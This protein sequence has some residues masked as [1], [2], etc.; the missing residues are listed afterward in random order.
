MSVRLVSIPPDAEFLISYCARVSNP[1]NQLSTK[2]TNL[3]KYCIK[4]KHWSIFEMSNMIIE[5]ECSKPIA[6]QILRHRSFCFQQFSE[7]YANITDEFNEIP[8]PE[9]RTQDHKNR[10]NSF[11]NQLDENLNIELS[12]KI[13]THFNDALNLYKELILHG[14]AKESAR[15]IMPQNTKTRMYMSGNIRNWIHYIQTRTDPSTQKEHR[16]VANKIKEI[17]KE[18]LPI[19]SEALEW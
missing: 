19:I 4:N 14:V 17:F 10:Q 16:E 8:I 6:T 15:F 7:R 11:S 5:I 1:P 9:L 12:E 13:K 2:I 18:S 3:L